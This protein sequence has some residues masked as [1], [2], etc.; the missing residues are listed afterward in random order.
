MDIVEADLSRVE[1]QRA[2]IAMTNAYACDR[3]GGA[4]PLPQDVLD[5]LVPALR[6]HPTTIIFLAFDGAAPVGIATCFKAFS[7][8]AAK[9]LLNIHDLAVIPSHQGRGISRALLDAVERK[10]RALGC[11][12]VTLEVFEGND[13]ARSV[14][15]AAG[16][17]HGAP[18]EAAGGPLFLSKPL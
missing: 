11:A 1:H 16:F 6:A 8:F 7:T 9:P 15:A 18:G 17:L 10:A 2:V 12:K 4:T 13:R 14:Y 5:R 3:M